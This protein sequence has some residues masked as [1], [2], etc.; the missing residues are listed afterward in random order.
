MPASPPPLPPS[1]HWVISPTYHARMRVTHHCHLLLLPAHLLHCPGSLPPPSTS[2]AGHAEASRGR[3]AGKAGGGRHGVAGD[4]RPRQA[5]QAG[6]CRGVWH[7]GQHG[8]GR[9]QA[10]CAGAA[11]GRPPR[12][13]A[14]AWREEAVFM[15]GRNGVGR[16]TGYRHGSVPSLPQSSG[17]DEFHPP[18]GLRICLFL[19]RF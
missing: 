10:A 13:A 16:H 15:Q 6:R 8:A 5:W 19:T 11:G 7:A 17:P 18:P 9:Q 1:L 4:G 12:H 2:L 3:M 14:Y